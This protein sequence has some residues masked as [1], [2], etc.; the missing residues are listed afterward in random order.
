MYICIT[1]PIS[2]IFCMTAFYSVCFQIM[3]GFYRLQI[4]NL[5]Y[6]CT[7]T[8]TMRVKKN[9]TNEVHL[10]LHSPPHHMRWLIQD[11]LAEGKDHRQVHLSPTEWTW[12]VNNH[13]EHVS[14]VHA[15]LS[16]CLVQ[17]NFPVLVL[18]NPW[19]K[20]NALFLLVLT[21]KDLRKIDCRD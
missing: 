13:K 14:A 10:F 18:Q 21:L 16:S 1:L 8:H 4:N 11:G 6:H 9:Q 5:I 20:G 12:C 2:L 7:R 3:M 15:A 19:N 17:E